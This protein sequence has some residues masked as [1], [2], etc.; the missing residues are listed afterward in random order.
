MRVPETSH[1]PDDDLSEIQE[2]FDAEWVLVEDPGVDEHGRVFTRNSPFGARRM[3]GGRRTDER[4]N[5]LGQASV[6]AAADMV[7]RAGPPAALLGSALS[8]IH[9]LRSMGRKGRVRL[10]FT[11]AFQLS[12]NGRGLSRSDQHASNPV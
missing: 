6:V 3:P 10:P 12:F 1:E 4:E 11:S 8:T 5:S 7:A 9:A 2:R